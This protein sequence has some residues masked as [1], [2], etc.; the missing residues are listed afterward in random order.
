VPCKE[1][2]GTKDFAPSLRCMA[3]EPTKLPSTSVSVQDSSCERTQDE[4]M[5]S[6]RHWMNDGTPF[7]NVVW[8]R[9]FNPPSVKGGRGFKGF[10]QKSMGN[11]YSWATCGD[12]KLTQVLVIML[13]PVDNEKLK[14][15]VEMKIFGVSA[16]AADSKGSEQ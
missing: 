15:E 9:P 12:G 1:I 8:E 5:A 2:A 3:Q 11:R 10:Y 4:M 16:T 7:F 14:A 6:E 13:S